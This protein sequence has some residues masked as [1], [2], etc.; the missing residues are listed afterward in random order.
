MHGLRGTDGTDGVLKWRAVR[1]KGNMPQRPLFVLLLAL[2]LMTAFYW[3]ARPVSRIPAPCLED[4]RPELIYV[5]LQ[6]FQAHILISIAHARR[7]GNTR[8]TV[9]CDD[10]LLP[11]FGAAPG[12]Q[13]VPVSELQLFRFD[14]RD[15]MN[16]SYRDGF[17]S[18]CSK[19]LFCLAAYMAQQKRSHCYHVENDVLLYVPLEALAVHRD[20]IYMVADNFQRAVPSLLYLPSPRCL[21]P[22]IDRYDHD[23]SDMRNLRLHSWRHPET[24]RFFP[25]LPV[26]DEYPMPSAF[27]SEYDELQ[28]VFDANAIGQYLGGVDVRNG[29]GAGCGYEN[30][31]ALHKYSHFTFSWEDKGSAGAALLCPRIWVRGHWAPVANLHVHSKELFP[32]SFLSPDR[33]PLPS[34]G[35]ADGA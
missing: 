2:A 6:N 1:S 29:E 3:G 7:I 24:T 28:Y 32:F 9:L 13:L 15:R 26:C 11:R 31:D 16:R 4:T 8:I 18:L 19:R 12:V 23:E 10:A 33:P 20:C 22:L 34:P 17:W 30:R 14:E 21:Q 35:R 5:C 27:T 25:V